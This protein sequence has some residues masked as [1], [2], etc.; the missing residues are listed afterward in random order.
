MRHLFVC[1][2]NQEVFISS[3]SVDLVAATCAN[4]WV[5][6]YFPVGD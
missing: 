3:E 1:G 6:P 4:I 2:Y 5:G